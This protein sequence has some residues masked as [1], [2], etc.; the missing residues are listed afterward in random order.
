MLLIHILLEYIRIYVFERQS[1]IDKENHEMVLNKFHV[2]F[3]SFFFFLLFLK[4]LNLLV[5]V[6]YFWSVTRVC[7][8]DIYWFVYIHYIWTVIS[9]HRWSFKNDSLDVGCLSNWFCFFIFRWIDADR[10]DGEDWV[11]LRAV[12]SFRIF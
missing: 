3:F 4:F 6:K 1:K 10:H 11:E 7:Q 5:I 8:I 12:W 9:G 2:S